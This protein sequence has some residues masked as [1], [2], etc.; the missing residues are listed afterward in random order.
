[1][2]KTLYIPIDTTLN[3]EFECPLLVK[4]YDTLKFKFA[5]FSLGILQDLNGQTVDL[6]L[7]KK[8]G[9]T[10][11]K[12][13][14][15]TTL[16]IATI[17]L[18]K[19]ASACIGEVL[20]EIVITDAGGQ[21]TSNIFKFNVSNSLT[22]DIEIKSKDD[23]TTIE[24]M[25]ALIATYKNEI[26]AIGESTQAVEALNNITTYIDTNLSELT[27][28]NAAAV[29]NVTDLKKENDRADTNIPGLTNLND[30]AE[31]KL[32]EFR[33]FDT[34]NIVTTL[35]DH[36]SQLNENV[37]DIETAKSNIGNLDTNKA[38]KTDL[39]TANLKINSLDSSKANKTDL[40]NPFNLKGSCL[41]TALP[42]N[43]AV[44]D[45][46]Y[47]TD[48]KYRK[49]WNGS[50]WFQSS[51][52]ESNYVDELNSVKENLD[53]AF[54]N[55][56][57]KNYEIDGKFYKHGESG[58]WQDEG[59][60]TTIIEPIRIFKGKIYYFNN[61]YGYFCNI[62]YDGTEQY[63]A[64]TNDTTNKYCGSFTA[65]NDGY[66]YITIHPEYE[67]T[68]FV[69][70]IYYFNLL[71]TGLD[72]NRILYKNIIKNGYYTING[73]NK[74]DTGDL[75]DNESFMLKPIKVCKDKTYYFKN[76]YAYFCIIQ[77]ES[78]VSRLSSATNNYEDGSFTAENDGYIYITITNIENDNKSKLFTESKNLYNLYSKLYYEPITDSNLIECGA[79]KK[80][81]RLRDA[82]Q[83]ACKKPNMTVKVYPGTYDL[84]E[85]F[86][87]EIENHS[88][89]GIRLSNDVH[90][91]F[92]SGAKS[93]AIFDDYDS[94]IYEHFEPFGSQGDGSFILENVDIE[95][96]N[97]RYCV[98]DEH[99]GEGIYTH[100]YI[101][102]N[103]KQIDTTDLQYYVQCIGG[104]LGEHGY[105]E[106]DGGN[107]ES[108]TTNEEKQMPISYHNGYKETAYS[109][110]NIKNVYLK[111]KGRFRFGDYGSSTLLSQVQIIGCSMGAPTLHVHETTEMDH[112]NFEIFESNCEVRN[113]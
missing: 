103:M 87:T 36:G 40:T 41:S 75:T 51:L 14:T 112:E 32:Q 27:S 102:C 22:E 39:D 111:N 66:V 59:Q 96:K 80:Y 4:K 110:I 30:T 95:A 8:D 106:I 12:T 92:M 79:G 34:S 86:K 49:T 6:I 5:I 98:H 17:I 64:F 61:I 104:G 68:Y 113:S 15:N 69:N 33:E 42:T 101:N 109:T 13:I 21:V 63:K 29:K 50:E 23:I 67:D 88:G 72:T 65:E 10:I 60:T 35:R 43:A 2:Q 105:I 28:K 97:C 85:E 91:L 76:L 54:I 82:I 55:Y 107:Y 73:Q 71:E 48:L 18:D 52:E 84:K 25:R 94:W 62:K 1:M 45:T 100:K 58:N 7:Y 44:N 74:L 81:T 46:W 108:V 24:D 9:T 16:N 3:Y 47:C 89:T 31:E 70:N 20:G 26:S 83:E 38:N 93:T 37:K 77:Y 56:L 57:D 90:I 53:N 99:A 11:Q 78:S 19:N